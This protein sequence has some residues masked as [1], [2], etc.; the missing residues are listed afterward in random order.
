[1]LAKR[2]DQTERVTLTKMNSQAKGSGQRLQEAQKLS[3]I[4]SD[5]SG[6][7]RGLNSSGRFQ[8]SSR[9]VATSGQQRPTIAKE[10]L[11]LPLE[12]NALETWPHLRSVK[13]PMLPS[14]EDDISSEELAK[15]MAYR[16]INHRGTIAHGRMTQLSYQMDRVRSSDA[17]SVDEVFEKF[18]GSKELIG[19]SYEEIK[20]EIMHH[21]PVVSATFE[22]SQEF[23]DIT[24]YDSCFAESR[25]GN[26]HEV[27]IFGWKLTPVGAVWLVKGLHGP[28]DKD[29]FIPI[30]FGQFG[31]DDVCLA[32]KNSFDNHPWQD[33]KE[34]VDAHTSDRPDW[35]HWPGM[36][37]FMNDSELR[38][39][40]KCIKVGIYKAIE[41]ERS[42]VVRDV[43]KIA[44]SRK[45]LLK[46][47][48]WNEASGKW[49]VDLIRSGKNFSRVVDHQIPDG[50]TTRT[51]SFTDD[52]PKTHE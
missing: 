2:D 7:G 13:H 1:M 4:N 10:D 47:V 32:P 36:S 20:N 19:S 16:C 17:E 27:L 12:F 30:S 22:M 24:E 49:K 9:S 18:G 42:F 29:E 15:L 25:L 35:L 45:F 52:N 43:K 5:Y 3:G 31:I 21:G 34:C 6:S 38:S 23:L 33:A 51:N 50:I 44:R 8:G 28:T 41:D 11:P 37:L 40:G 48:T 46:E 39:L 14:P 26:V